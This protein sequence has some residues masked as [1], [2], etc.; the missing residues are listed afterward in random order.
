M[1]SIIK[2][3]IKRIL[4]IEIL[5]AFFAAVLLLSVSSSYRAVKEY[6]LWDM[7][8]FV[9]SAEENIKHGKENADRI[10]V[11]EAIVSLKGKQEAVYLV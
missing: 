7:D 2:A 3:E 4:K 1:N 9:A 6:E 8:G 10:P 11:E 5:L